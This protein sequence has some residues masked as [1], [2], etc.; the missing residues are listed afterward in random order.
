[1][2]RVGWMTPGIRR[3]LLVCVVLFPCVGCDQ[4][5]KVTARH[6]LPVA[7][8]TCMS[9][10]LRLQYVENSGAFLSA[11][12]NLSESG[13]FWIFT[14]FTGI[15]LIVLLAYV[16]TSRKLQLTQVIAL[17]LMLGGGAGNLI[18]RIFNHGA[19]I[20]FLNVGV[21]NLRTGVFNPADVEIMVGITMLLL[22]GLAK[23]PSA[24]P[25]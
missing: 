24:T 13:R 15:G 5:A 12:S 19:V 4:A 21:G 3:L 10:L 20:D 1:M 2:E 8:V 9:G 6:F 23:R 14:I 22:Q 17:S 16:A 25:S 7:P 11:G 18:D